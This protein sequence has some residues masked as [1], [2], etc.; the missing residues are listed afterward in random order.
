LDFK[1]ANGMSGALYFV[2]IMGAGAALFDFDNDG[3]L[4]AYLVQGHPLG[5]DL[6]SIA[7]LPGDRLYRNDLV[8]GIDGRRTM[9]FTDVT[10]PSGLR[11]FGYGMG[12]ATGDFNNDGWTDLYVTNW[13]DNQLWHN[14][15]DGTFTDVTQASGTNDPRWSTSAAFLDFDLDGWQDL[16][17]VNYVAY[18]LKKDHPCYAETSGQQD[19]CGP[20][21]YP[22]EPDLLLRNRGDG[23]FEDVTH[24][25]GVA[26]Q[27]G[28]GLG[29]TVADLNDDTWPDI[30]IANDQGE[31]LLWLNQEG[32]RFENH[33]VQAGVALNGAGIA[34]ASMGVV[35]EDFDGEGHLDLFMTHLTGESN[36]LYLN[37]GNALFAD[38]SRASGLGMPSLPVTAFGVAALDYDN[39]GWP[40]LFSANGAVKQ[41]PEQRAAGDPFPLRQP[42]QLYRNRGQ[43]RFEDISEEAGAI[44]DVREVSRGVAAGDVDNDGDTDL[45]LSNNGGPARLLRNDLGQ[46]QLWLGLRLI[47]DV[48]RRDVYGA[49]V[50]L[51]KQGNVI[52]QRRVGTDGSYCSAR[53]PRVLFGLGT[54]PLYDT[55]RV[56]WPGGAVEEWSPLEPR[57]YHTLVKGEGQPVASL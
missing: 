48:P 52:A 44:F 18:T 27:Y 32:R 54:Q 22:H 29:V 28:A 25:G 33:A 1:H 14:N 39:D 23:T 45:L 21:S 9:Q 3:D 38:H 41:I 4:D 16:V 15:G 8:V 49:R 30:Y 47:Q 31:N 20:H 12:V 11:A 5:A 19:Y 57:R 50:V 42:N 6:A 43:A 53:D 24:R 35:A 10:T 7:N 46:E 37:Q 26:G 56:I 36:T 2:E 51:L 55:I 40:D 13:G 17:V 34:E